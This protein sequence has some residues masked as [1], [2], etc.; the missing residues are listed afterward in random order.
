MALPHS[1]QLEQLDRT[2]KVL[3]Q[4]TR[5]QMIWLATEQELKVPPIALMVRQSE[6]TVLRWLTRY[7]AEGLEAYRMR[8]ALDAPCR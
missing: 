4:R 8:Q 5:A 2:P 6:A 1:A 7:L 3:R